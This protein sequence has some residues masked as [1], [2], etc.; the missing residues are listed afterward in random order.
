M[1]EASVRYSRDIETVIELREG[2]VADV[3]GARPRG[4]VLSIPYT[5]STTVYPVLGWPGRIPTAHD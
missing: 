4:E 3:D 2:A 1:G 5:S